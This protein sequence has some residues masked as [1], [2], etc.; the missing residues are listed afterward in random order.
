MTR[1]RGSS[2]IST[3]TQHQELGSLFYI[4]FPLQI[5]IKASTIY[6]FSIECMFTDNWFWNFNYYDIGMLRLPLEL[7]S[8][9]F[10]PLMDGFHLIWKINGPFIVGW[11]V[12]E[13]FL[14][15]WMFMWWMKVI[16]ESLD[17][18]EIEGGGNLE[19]WVFCSR[20]MYLVDL[21]AVRS[22]VYAKN[23]EKS[24]PIKFLESL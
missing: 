1:S 23:G 21:S 9:I 18:K 20:C 13:V 14:L 7:V 8:W 6:L 3:T 4:H 2:S 10:S 19:N 5:R 22:T 17:R 24:V 12:I 11:M 15:L 16:G